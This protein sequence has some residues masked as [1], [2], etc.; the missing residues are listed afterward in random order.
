MKKGLLYVVALLVSSA[1]FGQLT[2]ANEP[3]VGD[4]YDMYK[5]DSASVPALQTILGVTGS[6]VTWNYSTVTMNVSNVGVI[7]IEDPTVTSNAASYPTSTKA[8]TQGTALQ[9]FNSTATERVSQGFV[10]SEPT[11]GEIVVVFDTDE[12]KVLTYPFSYGSTNTDTYIGSTTT[13]MGAAT[14]TGKVYSTIDGE[15]TLQ[16]P[17]MTIP[18]L[19]RLT[20]IDTSEVDAG[21]LSVEVIRVQM[22]YY[23]KN[24][25]GL[26]VFVDAFLQMGA[27]GE[28]RQ[29]FSKEF[30]TMGITTKEIQNL[31][32]FPNPS[33]GKF[34]V[35]GD[36][37]E[38]AVEVTD[39]TGKVVYHSTVNAGAT[40]ALNDAKS[41]VYF[42]KVAAGDKISVQKMTIK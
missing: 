15:G 32:I 31:T 26:P 39:V 13:P 18:N 37:T 14:V 40:V 2:Q 38:A 19:M 22:E 30:S 27:F 6:N 1:S 41:G 4:Y 24:N 34:V 21:F 16:L 8:I 10:F 23:D 28:D 42:V 36:F 35:S 9:Y 7:G 12:A 5:I 29:V 33:N 3:A 11:L 17:T 20:T 25:P